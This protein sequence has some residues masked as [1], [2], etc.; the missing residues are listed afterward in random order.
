MR[1]LSRPCWAIRSSSFPFARNGFRRR[2]GHRTSP[3]KTSSARWWSAAR[4]ERPACHRDRSDAAITTT[5]TDD[6]HCMHQHSSKR[7]GRAAQVPPHCGICRHKSSRPA[8]TTEGLW[9][10][11]RA[12]S[13]SV[14]QALPDPARA[15]TRGSLGTL[16]EALHS[17]ILVPG[18]SRRSLLR[19]FT[20][21]R[22]SPGAGYGPDLRS[23]RR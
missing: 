6:G 5:A 14:S 2:A 11:C 8:V 21:Q 17:P 20:V 1:S 7:E 9:K 22:R 10:P 3:D 23:V 16:C 12:V 19:C 18:L 15:S 13:P 4:P